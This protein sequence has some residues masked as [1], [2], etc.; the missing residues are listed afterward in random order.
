MSFNHSFGQWKEV[1][2]DKTNGQWEINPLF[3][4]NNNIIAHN[5]KGIYLSQD[6]GIT[7]NKVDTTYAMKVTRKII[8]KDSLLL[9]ASL[10]GG[11]VF[12]SLDSGKTWKAPKSW[13]FSGLLTDVVLSGTNI[14]ALIYSQDRIVISKDNGLTWNN[15]TKKPPVIP[16]YQGQISTLCTIGNISLAFYADTMYSSYDSG[17]VWQKKGIGPSAMCSPIVFY[18]KIF[19]SDFDKGISVSNDSGSTWK[20]AFSI[21]QPYAI[22][23]FCYVGKAIFAATE[24]KGILI[25]N[26]SGNTWSYKNDGLST[27]NIYSLSVNKDYLYCGADSGRIFR[28][29]ILEFTSEQQM[30][31]LKEKYF[32]INI[33]PNPM[34][35]SMNIIFNRNL[36]NGNLQVYDITGKEVKSMKEINSANF[37]LQRENLSKGEYFLIVSEGENQIISKKFQIQ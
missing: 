37:L 28:R 17:N 2:R 11:G 36:K 19:S 13:P 20:I 14:L 9:A 26:D 27:F 10:D 5:D 31:L 23:S 34:Q 4:M 6:N 21:K 18:N 22:K 29:S 32:T 30:T 7:W 8:N 33:F 25:S 3:C 35:N 24:G 1:F 12:S 15:V 16:S